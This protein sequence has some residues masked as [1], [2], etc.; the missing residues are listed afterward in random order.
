MILGA[1]HTNNTASFDAENVV[2]VQRNCNIYSEYAILAY[3][4]SSNK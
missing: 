2:Y 4:A 1:I 3:E